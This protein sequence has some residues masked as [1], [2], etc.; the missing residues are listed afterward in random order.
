MIDDEILDVV[1]KD[2]TVI[3]PR[4]VGRN[5]NQRVQTCRIYFNLPSIGEIRIEDNQ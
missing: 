3:G 4:Q 5:K 2:D 1:D